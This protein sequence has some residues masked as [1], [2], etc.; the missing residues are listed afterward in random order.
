M[1]QIEKPKE[2]LNDADIM[3]RRDLKLTY[4]AGLVSLTIDRDPGY[5]GSRSL[6]RR[7]VRETS[8]DSVRPARNAELAA[9]SRRAG[10]G[11]TG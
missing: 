7:F 4:L 9:D 5:S 8:G 10:R 2:G 1:I 6:R 11:Q 3:L